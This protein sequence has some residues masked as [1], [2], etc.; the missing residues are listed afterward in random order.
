MWDRR[1]S[2]NSGNVYDG[3]TLTNV[4]VDQGF[5]DDKHLEIRLLNVWAP[6]LH[7]FGGPETRDFVSMWLSR[8]GVMNTQWNFICWFTR[9]K[10]KDAEQKSFDRYLGTI[11]SLDQMHNLNADVNQFVIERE[12][13]MGEV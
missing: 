1:V 13:G 7:E 9:M 5:R 11:M 12:F 10:V 3:D 6:E 4:L 8:Y 2:L